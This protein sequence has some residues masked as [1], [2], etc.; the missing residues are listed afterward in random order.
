MGVDFVYRDTMGRLQAARI[1]TLRSPCS[2]LAAKIYA[3]KI[4]LGFCN[5]DDYDDV[6]VYSN[7]LLAVHGVTGQQIYLD[8]DDVRQL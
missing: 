2:I 5:G 4:A 6:I 7:S 1:R 3:L 8:I